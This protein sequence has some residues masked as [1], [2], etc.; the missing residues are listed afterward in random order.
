MP[1]HWNKLR[2]EAI[3]FSTALDVTFLQPAA[4]MQNILAEWDRMTGT[5]VYRVPYP[6]KTK[7]SLVDLEDVAE[8]AAT[9]LTNAGHTDATYE[10]VGTPPISQVEI[11][12]AFGRALDRPVRAEAETVESWGHRAK[13]AGMSDYAR[14]TL[15]RMFHVYARDGLAGNCN[16]LGWLLAR[17]PTSLADFAARVAAA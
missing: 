17:P 11:A 8:A 15:I 4:Y 10:L 2:V 12:E 16:V 1:H 6:I 5:G 7:L 14:E 13:K 9:V 3:L